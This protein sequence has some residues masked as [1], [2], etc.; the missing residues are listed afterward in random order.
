VHLG[1]GGAGLSDTDNLDWMTDLEQGVVLSLFVD[2]EN[3][4]WK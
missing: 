3:T 2:A 4:K 1:S